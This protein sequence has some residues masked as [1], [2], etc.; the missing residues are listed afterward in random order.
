MIQ[1]THSETH[2][3]Q[4]PFTPDMGGYIYV[5]IYIYITFCRLPLSVVEL[6]QVGWILNDFLK[7]KSEILNKTS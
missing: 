2:L 5:Y 6:I 7:K 4:A 3:S 1:E